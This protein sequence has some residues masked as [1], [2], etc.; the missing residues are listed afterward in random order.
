M[1]KQTVLNSLRQRTR[2]VQTMFRIS[3]MS[4]GRGRSLIGGRVV[5]AGRATVAVMAG[6][7][8]G[9][10]RFTPKSGQWLRGHGGRVQ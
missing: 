8:V 3:G 10:V 1:N 5:L 2:E 7:G 6:L 9:P 4:P